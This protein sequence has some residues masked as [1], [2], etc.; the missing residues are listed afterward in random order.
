[1]RHEQ[2]SWTTMRWRNRQALIPGRDHPL[3]LNEIRDGDVCSVT[4]VAMSHDV[5]CGRLFE[6]YRLQYIVK[7]RALPRRIEFRPFG[8]A[9]NIRLDRGLR[10]RLELCPLPFAEQGPAELKSESILLPVG[11]AMCRILHHSAKNPA[12]LTRYCHYEIIFAGFDDPAA[13]H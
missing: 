13:I 7:C 6:A 4:P 3:T 11:W 2:P 12:R 5:G 8:D 9:V 10:E 1:M